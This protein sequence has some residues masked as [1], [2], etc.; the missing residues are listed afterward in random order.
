MSAEPRRLRTDVFLMIAAKVGVLMLHVVSSVVVARALGV[1]GRG[2]LAVAFSLTLILVQVGTFGVLT[3][4]PYFAAREPDSVGRL[5][6]NSLWL[7]AFVGVL[8]VGAGVVV[9]VVAPEVVEGLGWTPLLIALAGVPFSLS[10]QF[11]H[12]ILLGQGRTVAYNFIDLALGVVAL[13]A[14]FLVLVPFG[15]G[16]T[17]AIVVTGAG[18]LAGTLT[19][20]WFLRGYDRPALPD[21]EFMKRLLGYGFRAYVATLISFMVIRIDMLMVNGYLGPK[22]AGRYA[23][24]VALVDG[25]YL[26]PTTVG[27][28]LFP[29]VAR[30]GAT[31]TS[32]EV[33]RNV[34]VLYA[35]VCLVTVPFASLAIKILYGPQFQE[36]VSLY[37]WLLPG[38]FSLGMVTI[39]SNHFAGRGFPLEAVLVWFAGLGMN[40]ALNVLFL[41]SHGTYIA[42]LSSSA[43]YVL[44]LFLHMAMFAREA[45]GWSALRPRP[46]EV[47]RMLRSALSRS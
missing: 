16:V 28:N 47:V 42:S 4:N 12:S 38:A 1:D 37:F 25:L 33:F 22:E 17:A 40:V 6:T 15:G 26:L 9:R 2:L 23:V 36:A 3:A 29:R 27:V 11:L 43:A 5:V 14:I 30:G 44:L 7:S 34:A 8:L 31:A 35:L 39:L 45:G 21:G 13:L 46:G 10:N 19:W 20:L 41:E 18:Y 32:A 24:A